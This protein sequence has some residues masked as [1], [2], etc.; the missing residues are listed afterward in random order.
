MISWLLSLAVFA[1]SVRAAVSLEKEIKGDWTLKS[2]ACNGVNQTI[3]KAYT[4]SFNGPKGEYISKTADCTQIESEDYRYLDAQTVSIKSGTRACAPN[5]CAADLPATECGKETNP[6]AASFQV[7]FNGR[8][9]M[10]LSTSDPKAF[11]CT[12]P[13]QS[14]PAVFKF[15]RI[16]QKAPAPKH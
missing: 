5:P 14:K 12:G 9:E 10:I 13:G 7:K 8:K 2:L 3:D 6:N 4:L 15:E 16:A 11:D 1:L